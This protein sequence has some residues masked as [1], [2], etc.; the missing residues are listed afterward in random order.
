MANP[1]NIG[2]IAA[3][4]G[5]GSIFQGRFTGDTFEFAA[6]LLNG[7]ALGVKVNCDSLATYQAPNVPLVA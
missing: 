2:A 3:M 6:L 1:T 7:I 5:R 4:I